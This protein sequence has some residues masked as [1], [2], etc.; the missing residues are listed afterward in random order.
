MV[1]TKAQFRKERG[2]CAY[3]LFKIPFD[4]ASAWENAIHVI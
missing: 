2:L 3:W 4:R 1:K